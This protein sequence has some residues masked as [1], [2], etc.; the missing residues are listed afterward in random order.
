MAHHTKPI[1]DH[2]IQAALDAYLDDVG[3]PLNSMRVAA[4][5]V[6]D[7]IE[8][9]QVS[10]LWADVGEY[11]QTECGKAWN[12]EADGPAENGCKFC[13][14]CGKHIEVVPRSLPTTGDE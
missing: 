1:P 5:I 11:W 13:H 6:V 4:S 7:A 14:G 3:P 8:D 12:F 10:C 2:V 9:P